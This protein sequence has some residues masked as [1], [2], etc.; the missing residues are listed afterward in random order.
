MSKNW[1]P[2]DLCDTKHLLDEWRSIEEARIAKNRAADCWPPYHPGWSFREVNSPCCAGHASPQP[3]PP[4]PPTTQLP[5][6]E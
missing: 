3:T 4:T 1:S 6:G 2:K 5:D